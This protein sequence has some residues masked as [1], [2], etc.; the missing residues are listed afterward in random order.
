MILQA[1]EEKYAI[2]KA[3]VVKME[4]HILELTRNQAAVTSPESE[5]T[6]KIVKISQPFFQIF[7]FS[8]SSADLVGYSSPLSISL[9]SSDGLSVS[10]RSTTELKNIQPL[11][12][13]N[14]L[15]GSSSGGFDQVVYPSSTSHTSLQRQQ[16]IHDDA[17]AKSSNAPGNSAQ[18][19][20]RKK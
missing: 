18:T 4:E 7:S 15:P 2:Q 20:P 8:S 5:K 11:I 19:S 6:S 10:L 14:P 13:G 9:A 3:V 1:L 16:S 12:V 17:T